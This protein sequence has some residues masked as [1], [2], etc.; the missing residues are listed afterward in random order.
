M[1]QLIVLIIVSAILI[2]AQPG[3]AAEAPVVVSRHLGSVRGEIDGISFLVLRGTHEEQGEAHGVLGGEDILTVLNETLIPQVEKHPGAWDAAILP[4]IRTLDFPSRYVTEI[5]A[6]LRGIRKALPNP[7][8][9]ELVALGREICVD[10]LRALSC[11]GD[12]MSASYNVGDGG[13]SSFSTWGSLT[14]DGAL[15]SGRN[16]DYGTFPGTIRFTL[17]AREA[18]EPGRLATLDIS[19]SGTV[20]A[21]TAMN[22]EGIV[23]MMHDEHGLPIETTTG[24]TPRPLVNRDAIEQ[25]RIAQRPHEIADLFRS[26]RVMTG[27]NTPIVFPSRGGLPGPNACVVEWDGNPLADGAAL[28]LPD[29]GVKANAMFCTNHYLQ[30]RDPG[31]REGNSHRRMASLVDAVEAARIA[32]TTIGLEEAKRMMNDVAV[33]GEGVTYLTA[34]AFPDERRM[35]FATTPETGVPATE[36][37]WVEITWDEIFGAR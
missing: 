2:S 6:M 22:S 10:D 9:R 14:S 28:R 8:D 5:D 37:R 1:T 11:V 33:R 21:S 3:I 25:L 24:H 32:N 13:C 20:G 34:I 4:M 16:L 29:E 15:I 19:A 30:R 31:E 36:G 18:T 35:V 26:K 17:I 7:E 12:I 27:N 23:L